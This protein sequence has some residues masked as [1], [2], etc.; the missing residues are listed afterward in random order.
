MGEFHRDF[1]SVSCTTAIQ[2]VL[3]AAKVVYSCGALGLW[4][5]GMSQ[6]LNFCEQSTA[7]D[8][9]KVGVTGLS[10][11]GK[12]CLWAGATDTRFSVVCPCCSG[13]SGASLSRRLIGETIA[14]AAT[15]YPHWFDQGGNYATL[16]GR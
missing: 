13:H 7:I 10:R 4:A 3:D 6:M 5:W 12:A 11:L 15:R 16:G 9:S 14:S 8:A 2:K 1:N